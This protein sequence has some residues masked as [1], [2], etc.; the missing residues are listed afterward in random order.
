MQMLLSNNS[1]GC[2]VVLWFKNIEQEIGKMNL[3]L[4]VLNSIDLF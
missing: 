1:Y 2:A 3:I 4:Q